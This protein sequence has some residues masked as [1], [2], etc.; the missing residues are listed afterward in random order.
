VFLIARLPIPSCEATMQD[1]LTP[2]QDRFFENRKWKG[3][4]MESAVNFFHLGMSVSAYGSIRVPR[5]GSTSWALLELAKPLV[6]K[7]YTREATS[8]SLRRPKRVCSFTVS[9]HQLGVRRPHLSSADGTSSPK[10]IPERSH[11][12]SIADRLFNQRLFW[13][14]LSARPRRSLALPFPCK[15]YGPNRG[16]D[17]CGSLGE[18]RM[19]WSLRV[20]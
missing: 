6:R 14:G 5:V 19:H 9:R 11:C 13:T 1:S 7:V 15:S 10:A 20:C 18:S 8:P 4:G 3:A 12:A 2:V 17:G 16:F